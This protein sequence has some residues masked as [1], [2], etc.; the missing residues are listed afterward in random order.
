[1]AAASTA[2]RPCSR[3]ATSITSSP[4]RGTPTTA[5]TTS[6][7]RTRSATARRATTL[8]PPST[9]SAG[10]AVGAKGGRSRA[11]RR[12]SE[13]W[14]RGRSAPSAWRGRS[15]HVRQRGR[16]SGITAEASSPMDGKRRSRTLWQRSHG[17]DVRWIASRSKRADEA[18]LLLVLVLAEHAH[19][20]PV[21][22]ALGSL[23]GALLA[24]IRKR[25]SGCAISSRLS[26]APT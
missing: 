20:R 15:I 21:V 22:R 16:G 14:S 17:G 1:M 9:W 8:P 19:E 23:L 2:V 3:R 10:A 26:S 11:D 5:S 13:T 4:G 7:Q 24:G 6:S 12:R 18:R 25:R